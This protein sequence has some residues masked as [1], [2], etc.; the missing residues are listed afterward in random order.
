MPPIPLLP[1][2][3]TREPFALSWEE[4]DCLFGFLPPSLREIAQFK[5]NTGLREQEVC[6]LRWEYETWS[7]EIQATVFVIPKRFGGRRANAGVKNRR[8]RV[9]ILNN[10]A[11]AIIEAR[12]DKNPDWVFANPRTRKPYGN[13]NNSGWQSARLAAAKKWQGDKGRLPRAG[14]A[15]VRV[16]DLKHTWES[17]LIA[18]GVPYEARQAL[19]GHKVESVTGHYSHVPLK[20]LLRYANLV[21]QKPG[22]VPAKPR[23]DVQSKIAGEVKAETSA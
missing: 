11:R 23:P 6:R 22:R 9:V 5:V 16:H 8:P 17:R 12:R 4:Q 18:A 19:L 15:T 3:D 2:V 7:D 13:L 1:E 21:K 14:F 10:A 20:D